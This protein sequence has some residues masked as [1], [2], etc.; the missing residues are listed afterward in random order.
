MAPR[1]S[2]ALLPDVLLALDAQYAEIL[3]LLDRPSAIRRMVANVPAIIG[4]EIAWVGEPVDADQLVLQHPV[5]STSGLLEGLV[6]PAGAGLGGKVMV[7]RR[8]LWV[9]D[10]CSDSAISHHFKTQA[11]IEG[12]KAMIAVPI[13]HGEQM[14]GVL[15]GANRA[16]TAFGDRVTAALEQMASRTA[17]AAVVAER[18]R[19]AAEVAVHEERRRLALE[20][21]D[22]VGAMLYTLG[23]GIRRLGT[24]PGLDDGVRSRLSI[25]SQQAVEAAAALRGS[26]RV[27]SAPPEQVALGV[28]VREHCRAF[29]ERTRTPARMIAL[30]ELPPL[31][32]SRIAALADAVREGLLNVEKH[33]RAGSVVVSLFATGDGVAVTVSDDGVGLTGDT[34]G[35]LGLAAVSDRL[36]RIGGRITVSPNDD[37]GVTLQAWI[38]A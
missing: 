32:A 12:I 34:T 4:V 30:T 35:G 14:L 13:M 2:A 7:Q 18:A 26:L 19:H 24:E 31:A 5:N 38:P 27:L 33:A 8:P 25:I 9:S 10:Y 28:A 11:Q 23:A 36:A 37:S 29:A 17:A 6:V 16:D 3:G 21:H 15:Y 22:T 20:L 1:E